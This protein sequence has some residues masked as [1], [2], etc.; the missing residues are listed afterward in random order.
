[1]ERKF[2]R[3]S[4]SSPEEPALESLTVTEAKGKIGYSLLDTDGVLKKIVSALTEPDGRVRIIIE[5]GDPRYYERE[6]MDEELQITK[7]KLVG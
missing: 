1:M 2:S 7:D 4:S 3:E 5:G 6:D